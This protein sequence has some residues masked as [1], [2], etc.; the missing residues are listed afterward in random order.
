MPAYRDNFGITSKVIS[1]EIL[2]MIEEIAK[3]THVKII[4]LYTPML[5]KDAL[6]KDGIHPGAEG[7]AILAQEVYKAIK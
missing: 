3:K 6:T 5:G 4:D 7:D 2:P 1:D